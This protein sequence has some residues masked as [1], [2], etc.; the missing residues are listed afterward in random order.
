MDKRWEDYNFLEIVP[1][2]REEKEVVTSI[3]VPENEMISEK[4]RT[5]KKKLKKQKPEVDD[6]NCR[7]EL[8]ERKDSR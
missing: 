5:D 2:A 7:V 6:S 8:D 4:S 3:T 1:L